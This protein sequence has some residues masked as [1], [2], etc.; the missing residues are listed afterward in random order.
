MAARLCRPGQPRSGPTTAWSS[1]GA[2]AGPVRLPLDQPR[3]PGGGLEGLAYHEAETRLELSRRAALPGASSRGIAESFPMDGARTLY[4][5]TKLAA[6]LLSRST[7]AAYGLHDGD[8]PLRR[9]GRTLADGQGRSGGVHILDARPPFRAA[10]P[11]HRLRRHR[12]AG[13]RPAPRRG[14]DGPGRA[15]SWAIPSAGTGATVNVGGGR[16]CSLSLRETTEL[17]R[18]I[19]GRTLEVR[20]GGR[21]S[22]RHPGLH[23][24]LQPSVRHDRLAPA[25][26]A[27]GD[28][29]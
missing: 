6:E 7:R 28:T 27:N 21:P 9:R 1:R 29:A 25:P 24:R 18:Q 16:E 12:Q 26:R 20:L 23:L 4:G 8:Q 10:A 3:L 17:C 22:G 5:A 15:S 13:A 14:P 11:L 19:T 2:A